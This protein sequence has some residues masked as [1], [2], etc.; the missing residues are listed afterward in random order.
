MRSDVIKPMKVTAFITVVS[1]GETVLMYG[2]ADV[3]ITIKT[4]L[5]IHLLVA[6]ITDNFILR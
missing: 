5:E 6:D 2:E 4:T 3:K 1:I